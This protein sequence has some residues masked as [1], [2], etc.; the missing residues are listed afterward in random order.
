VGVQAHSGAGWAG[1]KAPHPQAGL[2]AR[3]AYARRYIAA[4]VAVRL[5]ASPPALRV[6]KRWA[7]RAGAEWILVVTSGGTGER[8]WVSRGTAARD[9]RSLRLREGRSAQLDEYGSRNG[10]DGLDPVGL[11]RTATG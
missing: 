11:G 9:Q 8:D 2:N 4:L 5:Q 7:A 10:L 1:D 3:Q 6:A